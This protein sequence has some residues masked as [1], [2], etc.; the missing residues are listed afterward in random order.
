MNTLTTIDF[1]PAKYIDPCGAENFRG[2]A[3]ELRNDKDWVT[4]VVGDER[5]GKSTLSIIIASIVDPT[6]DTRRITFPSAELRYAISRTRHYKAIIQDEGA[7]SWLSSEGN[8]KESRK[9]TKAFMQIGAKNLA[10]FINIPDFE[11]VKRYLAKH[12]AHTVLRVKKRGIYYFYSKNR[13]KKIKLN[14]ASK[15]IIWP[16]P[17]FA[18]HWRKLPRTEFWKEYLRKAHDHKF[19]RHGE[20][21]KIVRDELRMEKFYSETVDLHDAAKMIHMNPGTLHTWAYNGVLK[22]RFKVKPLN[23]LHGKRLSITDVGRIRKQIYGKSIDNVV[24]SSGGE[25]TW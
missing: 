23:C 3:Q 12:R 15:T 17:N 18:G 20:N 2:I 21:P 24:K 1:D 6:F 9:M 14:A 25:K 22:K 10:I 7:E 11:S 4:L 19:G 16:K 5:L 13:A 8:T